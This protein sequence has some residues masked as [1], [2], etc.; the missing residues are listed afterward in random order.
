ML[1]AGRVAQFV[2]L[3]FLCAAIV[4]F[5]ERTRRGKL[6]W[7][8][9]VAGLDAVEEAVGR[10]TEMGRPVIC[11]HGIATMR[12]A[13]YGPQTIAGMAVLSHVARLCAKYGTRLIVPVRQVEVHPI[14]CELV[15]TAYV[16][17]GKPDLYK[18]DDVRFLSP[19]QFGY[20]SGYLGI[21]DRE[22]VAA[23]IMVGAYWAESL[24]LCEAGF[25][26]GAI[27]IGGTANWHQL[28]F[29]ITAA[30]YCLIGEEIFAAGAYLTKDPLQL[31]TIAGQD[32][33]KYVCT[34]LIIIGVIVLLA[35]G[36][37]WISEW[38]GM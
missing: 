34:A 31:G 5:I 19:F 7:I 33:G 29:F 38:L 36:K 10:A 22:R 32:I 9:K 21:M 3:L 37:N 23:N 30:D 35:T 12:D 2:T 8:R 27:Q 15:R 4:F 1:V 16:A 17:E 20:S 14:A 25:R 18:E 11:S 6:P 28:A 24:Q 26:A 13:T